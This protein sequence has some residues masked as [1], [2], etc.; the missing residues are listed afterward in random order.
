[1]TLARRIAETRR[2]MGLTQADLADRLGL[3]QSTLA[4]W[5]SGAREPTRAAV[6]R[7]AVALGVSAGWLEGGNAASV[8]TLG[9]AVLEGRGTMTGVDDHKLLVE[10]VVDH[11][12]IAF[13]G[14][15]GAYSHLAC[16]QA[17]PA[18]KPMACPSFEDAFAAVE[19]G[20]A[21]L[22]MIP[23]ENS[24]GGRV[25][26]VHHLL[27]ENNLYIVAEHFQPVHHCL[28]APKG[29]TMDGLKTAA[30]HPQALSQC[31][32][33]LR[34]LGIAPV[35]VADTAGAAQMIAASGDVTAGAVA[36]ELAAKTY[37]LDILRPRIE[38]KI[39]N[40]TRFVVMAR[41]RI[42]P[43]PLSGNGAGTKCLT[44]FVFTVR[45][46]P[47]ALYKS[48]GGFATNGVNMIRLESY[49]SVADY[50]TA[51]FYAEIEG[52]PGDKN[53]DRALEELDFYTSRVKLLGTY[54]QAEYRGEE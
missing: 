14:V 43:P 22:A 3:A 31:R 26:D 13:Q 20:E 37:D 9:G 17:F 51:R 5:E 52:H 39:G 27:P 53:V 19:T 10:R 12:V 8:G 42:E 50:A 34:E 24:L 49:I 54:P 44:S 11:P 35:K 40:V 6:K 38:D 29:A 4:R 18:M 32:K 25:A 46:V 21:G 36:S 41:Q 7:L 48:L 45:S 28:L 23:I 1:M 15:L 33:T 47:A 16:T 30:S 2:K